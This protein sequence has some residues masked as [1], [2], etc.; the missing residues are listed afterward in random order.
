M[1]QCIVQP[2]IAAQDL[3]PEQIINLEKLLQKIPW[4][5]GYSPLVDHYKSLNGT[6]DLRSKMLNESLKKVKSQYAAFLDFD[7]L[8][9]PYAY[10]WLINRL[11]LTGKAVAFGRVYA[12]N[13]TSKDGR[14]VDR[15]R[16]YEYG[17]SYEEF[18]DHNH[19][20]LHSFILD[21]GQLDLSNIIYFDDQKYMEDYLLT[22]QLFSKENADWEGLKS[23]FYIG[24]YIHSVDR[25][26]T[27][28]LTNEQERLS[29]L[30]SQEYIICDQR[31]CDIRNKIKNSTGY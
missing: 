12:T 4:V 27:L 24:D 21:L 2:F 22:L 23:N 19:A 28:A 17:Y 1:M 26:H 15:T 14:L 10:G 6:G 30:E 11:K 31:I 7:D 3:S 5:E 20:P 16:L 18:L 13:H 29:L 8:L 25:E 9:L